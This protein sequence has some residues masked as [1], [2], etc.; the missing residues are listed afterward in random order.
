MKALFIGLG[1][2][3]QR[4][5]RNL[6]R[7]RPEAELLAVRARGRSF[8]IGDDLAPDRSVDIIE[9]YGIRLFSGIAE[10]CAA[11]PDFAV[12]SNPTSLHLGTARALI[13][14]GVPVFLEKPVSDSEEGLDELLSLSARKNI[15]VMVGFMTRFHPCAERLRVL[16]ESRAVGPVLSAAIVSHSYLPSWHKYEKPGEFYAG[17]R[18][19]GGG[20]VLTETHELDLLHWYF[21]A[22]TRVWAV[23]A[24]RSA[25]GLD[26]EDTASALL[27]FEHQGRTFPASVSVSF[28]QTAPL[29][30]VEIFGER[31]R[32]SWDLLASRLV[33]EDPVRGLNDIFEFPEF[34]RND[35]F[36]LELEHFLACLKDGREPLTS[37]AR[38]LDGHR[39]ALKIRACVAREGVPA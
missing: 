25:L 20:A 17:R 14:R 28:A 33:L 13:E 11:K 5:L 26:V 7:L 21:G 38:V 37:L 30:R 9:K 32:L 19:L 2:V 27:K 10:A 6:K 8:E 29:R 39:T 22:P 23:G 35:L 4:H 3:G 24:G 34:K 12:V 31:G 15:P 16:L 1:G 18:E 36:I